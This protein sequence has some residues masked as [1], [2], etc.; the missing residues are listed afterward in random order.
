MAKQANKNNQL[1]LA[2]F[3]DTVAAQ[4]AA[5]ALK[6]WDKAT[7]NIKLGGIALMQYDDEKGKIKVQKIGGRLTGKGAMWGLGLGV[8]AGIFSG[9]LTILGGALFG[10]AIGAL[11]GALF[12]R[13][14][15]MT[16]AEKAD[17]EQHLQDGGA[18]LGV[19][20]DDFESEATTAKLSEL[21]GT[22]KQYKIPEDTL[23]EME[24]AAETKAPE[25]KE[26]SADAD[27]DTA[28]TDV[29]E[30]GQE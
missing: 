11:G 21:G 18:A 19:M 8:L 25:E 27:S 5:E 3:S 23:D 14:L 2:Y 30:Y 15:G 28:N 26:A 20:A 6:G 13:K 29:E 12:H 17:L 10:T 16:D 7:D 22:A 4:S 24:Q 9:G 1:I